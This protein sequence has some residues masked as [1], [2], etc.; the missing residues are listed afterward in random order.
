MSTDWLGLPPLASAHGGQID[1]MIGWVHLFMGL[2][3]A[4][5]GVAVRRGVP[6]ARASGIVVVGLSL[7][8]NFLFIPYHPVWSILVIALDVAIIVALA[9]DRS[10]TV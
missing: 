7:L 5:L 8:I 6:W 9:M 4:A 10:P 2:A 3:L 1:G